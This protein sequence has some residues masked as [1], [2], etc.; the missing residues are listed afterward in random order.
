MAMTGGSGTPCLPASVTNPDRRLCAPKSP[1]S[2]ASLAR[3][4]TIDATDPG[5]R[6]GPTRPF[7]IRRKIAPSWIPR[8]SA[9]P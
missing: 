4:F 2:P 8:H 6:A 5:S 1:S 9:T 7:Q 3:R